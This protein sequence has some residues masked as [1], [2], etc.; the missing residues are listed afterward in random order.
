MTLFSYLASAVE[1]KELREPHLLQN[2][3]K[4][5]LYKK[6]QKPAPQTGWAIHYSMG[7]LLAFVLKRNWERHNS[8]STIKRGLLSGGVSGISGIVIWH[9]AFRLQRNPPPIPYS[10][11]YYNLFLAH[12]IYSVTVSFYLRQKK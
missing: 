11:F 5:Q 7:I 8:E 4:D 2:I 10:R 3:V 9:T 1:E 12:L 6:K